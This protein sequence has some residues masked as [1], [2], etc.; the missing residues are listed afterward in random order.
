MEQKSK[1]GQI[2]R[3]IGFIA[4][5]AGGSATTDTLSYNDNAQ[6]S[7]D[8]RYRMSLVSSSFI[9]LHI[10]DFSYHQRMRTPMASR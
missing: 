6:H 1:D 10:S 8:H 2:D 4:G 3:H 5:I 7:F 9:M